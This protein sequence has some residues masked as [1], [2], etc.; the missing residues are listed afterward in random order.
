MSRV[1]YKA[2]L[3]VVKETGLVILCITNCLLKDRW[4]CC[5]SSLSLCVP[6]QN[7]CMV[8]LLDYN[9]L[10][11]CVAAPLTGIL[12]R[13][14]FYSHSSFL[15]FPFAFLVQLIPSPIRSYHS[16]ICPPILVPLPLASPTSS[17]SPP[18]ASGS[19]YNDGK[20]RSSIVVPSSGKVLGKSRCGSATGRRRLPITL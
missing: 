13:L 1:L 15:E 18:L 16:L 20:D 11:K 12:R 10:I 2:I 14:K 4:C 9:Y 5:F 6:S 3:T 17:Y 7:L 8:V 19:K